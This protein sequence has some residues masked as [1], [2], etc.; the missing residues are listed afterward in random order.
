VNLLD[1]PVLEKLYYTLYPKSEFPGPI[2]PWSPE[3]EEQE[4][5]F[6]KYLHRQVMMIRAEKFVLREVWKVDG[7]YS[8]GSAE[9]PALVAAIW[10]MIDLVTFFTNKMETLGG[11]EVATYLQ[12]FHSH[13][14]PKVRPSE[15]KYAYPL[16]YLADLFA[17][18]SGLRRVGSRP[19]PGGR[20]PFMKARLPGPELVFPNHLKFTRAFEPSTDLTDLRASFIHSGPFKLTRTSDFQRHLQLTHD[21]ELF[22][23]DTSI[24]PG[25]TLDD[26]PLSLDA[27]NGHAF[28]K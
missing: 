23:F 12:T 6:W 20:T 17:T 21:N 4:S 11:A 2:Q 18:A 1:E 7:D 9:K 27:Y 28:E 3:R 24:T 26:P 10:N 16:G 14:R 19:D 5:T 13:H 25:R 15:D 22:V 8:F